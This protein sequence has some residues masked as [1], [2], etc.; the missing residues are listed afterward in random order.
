M[1]K[2]AMTFIVILGV[3]ISIDANAQFKDLKI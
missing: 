1:K 2:L 3:G